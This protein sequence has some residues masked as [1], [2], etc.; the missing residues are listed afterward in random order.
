MIVF[1]GSEVLRTC[2]YRSRSCRTVCRKTI[3]A[4]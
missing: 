3:V 4:L 1:C 2:C